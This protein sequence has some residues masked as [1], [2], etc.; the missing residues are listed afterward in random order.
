MGE[1]LGWDLQNLVIVH[2]RIWWGHE[3]SGW[4]GLRLAP[5]GILITPLG[6]FWAS[7]TEEDWVW[8]RSESG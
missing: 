7:F 2:P 5:Q 3:V 4:P 8:P 6:S 1:V